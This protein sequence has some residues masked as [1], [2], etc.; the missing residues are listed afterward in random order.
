MNTEA[1]FIEVLANAEVVCS[2]KIQI[3]SIIDGPPYQNICLLRENEAVGRISL[4][5]EFLQETILCIAASKL[6]FDMIAHDFGCFSVLTRFMSE[7]IK[8]SQHSNV[9]EIPESDFYFSNV[10]FKFGY[11]SI[12]TNK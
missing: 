11:T 6:N 9:V 7:F 2:T 5:I 3:R 8:E 1:L 12:R 4:E 10:P